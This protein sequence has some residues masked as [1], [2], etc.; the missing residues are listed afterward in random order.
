LVRG[1]GELMCW[2]PDVTDL[3]RGWRASGRRLAARL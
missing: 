2:W 1:L 3:A